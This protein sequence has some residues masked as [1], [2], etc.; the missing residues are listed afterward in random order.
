MAIA[1]S[2]TMSAASV[3]ATPAASIQR[4]PRGLAA[5]VSDPEPPTIGCA[6]RPRPGPLG[7]AGPAIQGLDGAPVS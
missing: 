2:T 1:A 6:P 4:T 3:W 7:V 5:Q